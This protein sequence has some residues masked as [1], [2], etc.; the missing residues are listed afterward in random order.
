MMTPIAPAAMDARAD[1]LGDAKAMRA[2]RILRDAYIAEL[3]AALGAC[4][5]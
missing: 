3:Q 1:I 5:G 4:E 2:G